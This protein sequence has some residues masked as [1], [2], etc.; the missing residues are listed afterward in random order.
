MNNYLKITVEKDGEEIFSSF[1]D[2]FIV[3]AA[4][5][6]DRSKTS[7][8]TGLLNVSLGDVACILKFIIRSL[9]EAIGTKRLILAL[10]RALFLSSSRFAAKDL[11]R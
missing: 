3:S 5:V 11:I 2:C 1:S 6:S 8:V 9:K 7:G 4:N 10:G